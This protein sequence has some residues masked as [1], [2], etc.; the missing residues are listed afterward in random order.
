MAIAIVDDTPINLTLIQ[1]LVRK[2]TPAGMEIVCFT[3]PLEGLQWCSN[4]EPDLVIVDY[5]MPDINGIEFIETIRKLHPSDTVP[6]LMV[7]AAH[8]KEVRYQSLTAGANDFLTKPIDRHEFDPRVRTMLKLRESQKRL[9]S[10][11]D[12]LQAA[13][14]CK[15]ADIVARERET[16]AR[17][18]R[19]AEFRDP[20]TGGH[21]LRMAHYSILIAEQL[22]LPREQCERLL[23][24]AP[25]H[26]IGKVGTPDN[27]LLKPGRLTEEEMAIM[28]QHAS[29][30]HDIL[31]GSSS[32]MIQMAAEIALSHHEKF[33]GSGYPGGLVGDAIPLVGRIVA[34][35]DVFDAL[36]S[37]RPY[38][39]AWDLERSVNFLKEGRGSHFDPRC[40]DAFL[41]RWNEVLAVR[42]RF[43]DDA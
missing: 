24:A 43:R 22:G 35:A 29:I 25:M 16:V 27:I 42:E 34:V 41:A 2:L 14:I 7:T 19:A 6:I 32:P 23:T 8:E 39:P 5:M 9:R 13:V 12:D 15:T 3:S 40:V 33:D 11:N 20:E 37:T 21:I 10:W 30:G 17:L 4:N 38:K 1:A 18:A 36:T 31:N 26:D 28:R